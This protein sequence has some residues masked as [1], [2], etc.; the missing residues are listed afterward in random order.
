MIMS[1]EGVYIRVQWGRMRDVGTNR[2]SVSA[3]SRLFCNLLI[4]IIII[5]ITCTAKPPSKPS[6]AIVRSDIFLAIV[7]VCG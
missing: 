6:S 4:I 5:I 3:C 7:L 1:K 2:R